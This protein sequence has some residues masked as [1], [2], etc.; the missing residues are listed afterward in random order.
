MRIKST[1]L[2]TILLSTLGCTPSLLFT[3]Q[4]FIG[5]NSDESIPEKWHGKWSD[6]E[7]GN[8][9]FIARDSFSIEGLDYKIIKSKMNFGPDSLNGKDKIIFKDDWCYFCRYVELDSTSLSGYQ[10]L[11]ANIDKEG[12]IN[13][14][15]MSYDY[16]LR[17]QLVNKI[18]TIKFITTNI[19]SNGIYQKIEPRFVYAEIPEELNKKEFNH[20]IKHS[21]IA[22]REAPYFCNK[23]YDLDFFKNIAIS[24]TP[25]LIL[26]NTKKIVKRKENKNEIKY[27]KISNKNLK[28]NYIKLVKD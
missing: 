16:F 13:C 22:T 25:D 15:E 21:S 7:N 12:N 28:K 11:I 18:P 1:I 20:L 5:V 19:T 2:I 17:N 6:D 14:W 23:S 3:E 27:K 26:T 8:T 4:Q 24:R 9:C 10:V